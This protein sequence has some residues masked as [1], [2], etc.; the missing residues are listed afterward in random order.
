MNNL[1]RVLALVL[2]LMM[3]FALVACG[4][5]EDEVKEETTTETQTEEKTEEEQEEVKEEEKP[6]EKTAE[7]IEAEELEA[8]KSEPMYETGIVY[9]ISPANCT[10]T[11]YLADK[12]GFFEKYGIKAEGFQGGTMTEVLGTNAVQIGMNHVA[13]ALVP[14]ANGV[15]YS[16]VAGGMVGCQ[17][18]MVLGDSEV[19]TTAELK[20]KRIGITNGI[21]GPDYNIAARFFDADGFEDP[22]NDVEWVSIERSAGIAAL[23]SGELDACILP[24]SY[25]YSFVQDGTLKAIRSITTDEDFVDEPCCVTLMN[26]EF[27]E[28]NPL[29]AKYVTKA[30]Q[31]AQVYMG[32]NGEE[33]V[34]ILIDDAVIAGS[35]EVN[36]ACWETM[37]WG[38]CTDEFTGAAMEQLVSDYIRIGLITNT[39]DVQD[40]VSRFWTPQLDD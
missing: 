12:L 30:I 28:Q 39:D 32:E 21:G 10:T 35:F 14:A 5:T 17:A 8:M 1:K 34:Q 24:D 38:Q 16:V 20:G 2:A 18:L 29:M 27:I 22:L 3:A 40:V 19:E 15:N 36:I 9:Y 26:S 7:E 4:G 23:Q 31:E 11:P 33:C 37:R 6:A 25:T 13:A